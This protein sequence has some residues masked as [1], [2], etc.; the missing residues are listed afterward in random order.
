MTNNR[1]M[2]HREAAEYTGTAPKYLGNQAKTGRLAYVLT[3]PRRMMFRQ[4]DLD[5]WVK[6]WKTVEVTVR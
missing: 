3:S 4:A 1:L 6:T 2:L 5:A